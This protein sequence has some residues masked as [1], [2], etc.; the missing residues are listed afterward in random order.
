MPESKRHGNCGG[1]TDRDNAHPANNAI[2]GGEVTAAGIEAAREL[3]RQYG[4]WQGV[5][6]FPRFAG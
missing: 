6:Q 2:I 1:N 3:R 5:A 4:R